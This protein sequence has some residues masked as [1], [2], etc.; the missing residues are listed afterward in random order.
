MRDGTLFASS[1]VDRILPEAATHLPFVSI[2]PF[3]K[4]SSLPVSIRFL[5]IY[6]SLEW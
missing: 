5:Q 6:H 4:A 1:A 2:S 3:Q